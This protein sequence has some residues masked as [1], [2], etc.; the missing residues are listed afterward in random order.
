M[1]LPLTKF[2]GYLIENWYWYAVNLCHGEKF[3]EHPLT[4]PVIKDD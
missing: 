4:E 2:R 3:W 1:V